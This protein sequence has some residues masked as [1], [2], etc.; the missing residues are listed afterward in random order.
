LEVQAV[1]RQLGNEIDLL[2]NRTPP[3]ADPCDA[4]LRG[5]TAE[6]SRVAD[7]LERCSS[8]VATLD[9]ADRWRR[10]DIQPDALVQA[11][12]IGWARINSHEA[13]GEVNNDRD[14]PG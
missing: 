1:G 13:K 9:G 10:I 5:E 14:V 7:A 11:W 2:I 4:L 8:P 6:Q 12:Y 3:S